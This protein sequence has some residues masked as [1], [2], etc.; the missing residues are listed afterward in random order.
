VTAEDPEEDTVPENPRPA[1]A[2]DP[3]P[4]GS[5]PERPTSASVQRSTAARVDRE[6]RLFWF[7]PALAFV[8]GLLLGGGVV[9]LATWEDTDDTAG[10][11][12]APTITADPPA[13]AGDRVVVVPSSC[14]QGLEEAARSYETL[15]EGLAAARDLNPAGVQEA[16]DQLQSSQQVIDL[17]EECREAAAAAEILDAVPTT[18]R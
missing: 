6:P 17:A 1:G 7:L 5:A 13:N 9:A 3:E 15:R 14:V 16:L 18:G 11:A 4:K 8:V 12:P 2:A 10:P